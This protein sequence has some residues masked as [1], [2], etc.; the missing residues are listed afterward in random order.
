MMPQP[1]DKREAEVLSPH[2]S[3][4][5]IPLS[6]GNS[7]YSLSRGNSFIM[8]AVENL[9]TEKTMEEA[10][11]IMSLQSPDGSIQGHRRLS[12]R[13]RV[14]S[15]RVVSHSGRIHERQRTGSGPPRRAFERGVSGADLLKDRQ[16]SNLEDIVIEGLLH[17]LVIPL[18]L[19]NTIATKDPKQNAFQLNSF[20]L[21]PKKTEKVRWKIDQFLVIF[22]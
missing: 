17:F 20:F 15:G 3:S 21:Y 4:H 6:R 9:H 11:H 14:D 12:A 1:G 19:Y 10:I 13:R 7:F 8:G 16:I 22:N 2:E 5:S 18:H